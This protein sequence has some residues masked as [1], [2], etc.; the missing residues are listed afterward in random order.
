MMRFLKINLVKANVIIKEKLQKFTYFHIFHLIIL[1]L[2]LLI[3]SATPSL[4]DRIISDS[5]ISGVDNLPETCEMA[6]NGGSFISFPVETVVEG[7]R[8]SI[9]VTGDDY[10]T[11][12]YA[13][14]ACKGVLCSNTVPFVPG[15]LIPRE[16]LGLKLLKN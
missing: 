10:K 8:C 5:W 7:V 2:A 11:V 15:N 1:A 14:K 16:P 9:P 4:A 6:K 12:Q 13:I 3:L